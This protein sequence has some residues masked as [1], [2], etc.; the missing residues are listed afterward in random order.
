MIKT[1]YLRLLQNY[2]K[3]I[4]SAVFFSVGLVAGQWW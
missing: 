4:M 1:G 2:R 3:L